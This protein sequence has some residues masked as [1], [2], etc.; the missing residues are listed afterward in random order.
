MVQVVVRNKKK[1]LVE[2]I[3]IEKTWDSDKKCPQNTQNKYCAKKWSM[4]GDYKND[5]R[6]QMTNLYYSKRNS[7]W[8]ITLSNNEHDYPKTPRL[9]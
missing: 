5:Q 4:H 9:I 2:N 1:W 3:F 8:K 7:E 6:K